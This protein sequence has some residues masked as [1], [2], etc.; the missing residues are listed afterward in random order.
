MENAKEKNFASA[1]IYVHNEEDRI[2]NF[3]ENIQKILAKH[4]LKYEIICVND[5]S[6]DNSVEKIK[7]FAEN[8]DGSVVSIL[9]MSYYQGLEL[10]MNAGVDL[11]IGDFVFEFDKVYD[12]YAEEIIMQIYEQALKGY[13]IV[14]AIPANKHYFVSDSFYKLFNRYSKTQYKIQ[15]E[16]FRILS[17]RAINRVHSMSIR[18]PFRKA[19]YANCGL[20]VHNIDYISEAFEKKPSKIEKEVKSDIAMDSLILFTD[21]ASKF[22]FFMS[23]LMIFISIFTAAYVLF[24]FVQKNPIEGWT[25]TM[26]F[27]SVSFFGVFSVLTIIIKYLSLMMNLI[28]T[29]QKYNF[30][31]IE[32]ISK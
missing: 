32:K 18:I 4:F 11:S 13:D 16:S 21:V 10:S 30:E 5:F 1:V 12:D 19:M 17:R 2:V 24:V 7:K 15:R 9:H 14:N 27:M 6:T 29:K 31:S 3:L 22:T 23:A 8:I 20:K 26:L 25:T 28:F